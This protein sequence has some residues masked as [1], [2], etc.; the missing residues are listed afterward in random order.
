MKTRRDYQGM[1]TLKR[2]KDGEIV[3][4]V[5]ASGPSRKAG[6]AAREEFEVN[7]R[8]AAT[9]RE[10]EKYAAEEARKALLAK[11]VKGS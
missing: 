3:F 6:Q 2:L 4:E 11:S 10:I 5:M 7:T 9:L 1:V 8:W